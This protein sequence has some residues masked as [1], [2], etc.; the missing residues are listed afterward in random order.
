MVETEL[1]IC[2]LRTQVRNLQSLLSYLENREMLGEDE[3]AYLDEK[4]RE[5]VV[6]LREMQRVSTP[7]GPQ[8]LLR[9][10]WLN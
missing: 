5:V 7:R 6:R 1:V 3:F 4:L 10:S 8:S 9:A 2:H